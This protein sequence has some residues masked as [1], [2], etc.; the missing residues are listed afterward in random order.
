MLGNGLDVGTPIR[1]RAQD[2]P[3]GED[4]LRDGGF[5]NDRIGPHPLHH[6]V[7]FYDMPGIFGQYEERLKR[8][9]RQ[10]YRPAIAQQTVF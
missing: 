2:L 10:Q 3:Q 4:I 1:A 8:L 7:L 9:W 5:F 6:V